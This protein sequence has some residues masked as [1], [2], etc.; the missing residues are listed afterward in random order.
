MGTEQGSV[1][2][3]AFCINQLFKNLVLSDK[4]GDNDAY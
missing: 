2:M 1:V 4:P 3:S